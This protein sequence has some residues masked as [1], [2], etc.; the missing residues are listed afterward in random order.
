MMNGKSKYMIPLKMPKCHQIL[1]HQ[2][3]LNKTRHCSSLNT[4]NATYFIK[5]I[6]CSA[7]QYPVHYDYAVNLSI[8]FISK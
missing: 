4:V 5:N 3:C 2:W 7:C 1:I 6:L 8:V